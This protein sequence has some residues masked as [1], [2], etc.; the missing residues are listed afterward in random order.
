MKSNEIHK[1][2]FIISIYTLFE[3]VKTKAQI[4]DI[5]FEVI[6]TFCKQ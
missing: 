4:C 6:Q 3:L 2:I 1:F 5:F